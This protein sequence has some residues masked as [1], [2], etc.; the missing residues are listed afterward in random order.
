ME[1]WPCTRRTTLAKLPHPVAT[2]LLLENGPIIVLLSVVS[3]FAY[4]TGHLMVGELAF[5]V[6][7]LVVG[8]DTRALWRE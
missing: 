6:R 5:C 4:C 1:N 3:L 8:L 7:R 2:E